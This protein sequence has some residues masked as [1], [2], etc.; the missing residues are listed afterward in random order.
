MNADLRT[1]ASHAARHRP[2]EERSPNDSEERPGVARHVSEGRERRPDV[3]SSSR[4]RLHQRG[5]AA[6]RSDVG[7]DG[8]PIPAPLS[9]ALVERRGDI[10]HYDQQAFRAQQDSEESAAAPKRDVPRARV[11]RKTDA[12]RDFRTKAAALENDKFEH[13]TSSFSSELRS[14]DMPPKETR[15]AQAKSERPAERRKSSKASVGGASTSSARLQSSKVSV[16]KNRSDVLRAG[17]MATRTPA[18]LPSKASIRA[19]EGCPHSHAASHAA[20]PGQ[21]ANS[22]TPRQPA[23]LNRSNISGKS[24]AKQAT[25]STAS[26][27]EAG[28]KKPRTS[29]DPNVAEA[30]R[31]STASGK[32]PPSEKAQVPANRDERASATS[33]GRRSRPSKSKVSVD[34]RRSRASAGHQSGVS[35]KS[36][37]A[38]KGIRSTS[39]ISLA[40]ESRLSAKSSRRSLRPIGPEEV[41]PERIPGK[42]KGKVLLMPDGTY[43]HVQEKNVW[44]RAM[45]EKY[46]A[47]DYASCSLKFGFGLIPHWLHLYNHVPSGSLVKYGHTSER[48]RL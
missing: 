31:V 32:R 27:A 19:A 29:A 17:S 39:V 9:T 37:S 10:V 36:G 15:E 22:K 6:Q 11:S 45:Q 5:V 43:V 30:S 3:D 47:I 38:E 35:K 28:S 24:T 41:P 18:R 44:I 25:Q 34:S 1:L 33:A 8:S 23:D 14:A 16:S 48:L 21:A 13:S 46:L 12:R 7:R 26:K 40:G 20:G 2:D 42:P 4:R